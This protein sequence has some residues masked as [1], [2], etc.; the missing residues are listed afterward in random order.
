MTSQQILMIDWGNSFLKCLL[1]EADKASLESLPLVAESLI[2]LKTPA[3]LAGYLTHSQVK[4]ILISS[5]RSDAENQALMDLLK[6]YCAAIHFARTSAQACGVT[7]AYAQPQYLGIDRWLALLAADLL[8]S[9]I[10][11]ISI[12][13]A[14]TL[15]ILINKQHRGGQIIP[16]KQLMLDSLQ[17]TKKI[18]SYQAKNSQAQ[19]VLGSSTNDCVNY[20]ADSAIWSY[21]SMTTNA[22]QTKFALQRWVITGGGGQLWQAILQLHGLEVNYHPLLVFQGLLRE[23]QQT[24]GKH[25][26]T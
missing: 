6:P 7:C 17:M 16:A 21:L 26:P 13:T 3:E 8:A 12:G 15:D 10:G 2:T 9:K 1:V 19:V 18:D 20:G 11:V 14:I 4:K 25:E 24:S 22:L 23:Y 5:V